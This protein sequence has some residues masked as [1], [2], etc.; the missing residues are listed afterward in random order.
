MVQIRNLHNCMKMLVCTWYVPKEIIS[1]TIPYLF[2]WIQSICKVYV[3]STI[4]VYMLDSIIVAI[5]FFIDSIKVS[6]V[7]LK[8]NLIRHKNGVSRYGQEHQRNFC[9]TLMKRF[10]GSESMATS[11]QAMLER[12]KRWRNGQFSSLSVHERLWHICKTA[13]P[14]NLVSLQQPF[15]TLNT[16]KPEQYELLGQR[17]ELT[18]FFEMKSKSTS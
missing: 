8:T 10:R 14:E 4:G 5:F 18:A 15:Q 2:H 11:Q 16:I 9:I 1:F 6:K 12:N 13:S 3:D 17:S 7:W